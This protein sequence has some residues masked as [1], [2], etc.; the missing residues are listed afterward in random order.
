MVDGRIFNLLD[1]AT[2]LVRAGEA[3]RAAWRVA[4]AGALL[5]ENLEIQG[6]ANLAGLD[7]PTGLG[8]TLPISVRIPA[9][10]STPFVREFRYIVF[11]VK[12]VETFLPR[13]AQDILGTLG[14]AIHEGRMASGKAPFEA[15]VV[16][17]DWPEYEPTWK[18]IE[19]RV[20]R[21]AAQKEGG[22]A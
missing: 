19:E 3:D 2:S 12:D 17:K 8:A 16:E 21:E 5:R 4:D 18:A 1:E 13:H 7:Q 9:Q 11:K 6:R 20:A 22:D 10:P 15:A 14:K